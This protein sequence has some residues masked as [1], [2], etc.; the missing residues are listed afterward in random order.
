M[1]LL[2]KQTPFA[3]SLQPA[4]IDVQGEERKLE[5]MRR[6][7][8]EVDQQARADAFNQIAKTDP[9]NQLVE[10]AHAQ[11]QK[12]EALQVAFNGLADQMASVLAAIREGQE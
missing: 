8:Y 7:M 1:G 10:R 12:I 5:A 9:L 2:R 3:R 4:I 11:D 6:E